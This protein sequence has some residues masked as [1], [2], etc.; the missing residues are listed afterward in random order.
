MDFLHSSNVTDHSHKLQ[1]GH[2]AEISMYFQNSQNI[3]VSIITL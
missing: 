2:K 1:Q 3:P